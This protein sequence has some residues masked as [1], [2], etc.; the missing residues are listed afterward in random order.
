[1]GIL[2]AVTENHMQPSKIKLKDTRNE[3]VEPLANYNVLVLDQRCK[4]S[5][6]SFVNTNV[7]R[8]GNFRDGNV[9]ALVW[10][11]NTKKTP[12]ILLAIL[13][14]VISTQLKIK[15]INSQLNFRNHGK[16]RYGIGADIMT[17]DFDNNDLGINFETNYYSLYGNASY[18]I[19]NPTKYS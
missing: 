12:I 14:T 18:R 4:N 11:L 7:T 10:D 9:T 6:V 16:Y 3:L 19:L 13:N 17:K 2:N 8:N 15:G 1:V 5:S